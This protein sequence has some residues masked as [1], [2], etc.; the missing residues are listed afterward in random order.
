M[1][2]KN[3]ER[4]LLAAALVLMVA[5]A[6]VIADVFRERLVEAGDKA[7][8]FSIVT[9]SGRKVTP[10]DFG[11]KVLVL[12]FWATWCQPCVEEV[13]SLN[14]FAEQVR[15]DGVVVLGISVDTNEAKYRQFIQRAGVRFLT[16]RDPDQ[17]INAEYGTFKFPETYIIDIKGRVVEKFIGPENWAQ[18]EIINRVKAAL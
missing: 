18:P 3:T 13:P 8:G 7:P 15:G 10:A 2:S 1:Q 17:N 6:A 9:D 12:N 4:A 16:A 14:R 11:G 5:L